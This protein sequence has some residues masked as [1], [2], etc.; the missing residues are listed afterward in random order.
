MLALRK[1]NTRSAQSI[2]QVIPDR[3]VRQTRKELARTDNRPSKTASSPRRK[4]GSGKHASGNQNL[5]L[6]TGFRR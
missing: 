2:A 3:K 4:P 6:D 5:L 1:S